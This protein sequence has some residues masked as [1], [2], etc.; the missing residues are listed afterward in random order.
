M[1][2]F[3]SDHHIPGH[4]TLTAGE[5]ANKVFVLPSKGIKEHASTPVQSAKRQKTSKLLPSTRRLAQF[6]GGRTPP[7]GAR[8]IYMAGSWDLFHPGHIS[9]LKRARALGDFL[10]VGVLDDETVNERRY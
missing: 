4:V 5:I 1:L 2:N 6:Q 7:P 10:I 8:V 9:T 3:S